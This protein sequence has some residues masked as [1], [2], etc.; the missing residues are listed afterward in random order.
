MAHQWDSMAIDRVMERFTETDIDWWIA[1]GHAIDLFLGWRTRPHADLDVEIFRSDS[2]R[3]FD[4]FDGWDIH[5]VSD[6]GASPW[7]DPTDLGDDVFGSWIRPDPAAPWQVE[8]MFAGGDRTEWRF[9]REPS[10]GLAGSELVRTADSGIPYG[11]PEV[12]LL[13]KSMQHRPKDDVDLARCLVRM[14]VE[15]RSWLANAVGMTSSDHA[16]SGVL[17]ASL[18]EQHG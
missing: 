15:Q 10:I 5:V 11:T 9:Q 8:I 18:G 3:L 17:A 2:R 12:Q 7:T 6:R 13:Y 16:W 1:G 14:T 4:V